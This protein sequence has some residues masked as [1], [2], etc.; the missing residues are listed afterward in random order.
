MSMP[1]KKI[2]QSIKNMQIET[3]TNE[4]GTAIKY[5]DGWM[6]CLLDTTVTDQALNRQY[7]NTSLFFGTRTWTFPV[8]FIEKPIVNCGRFQWGTGASWGN[9]TSVTSST[10]RLTGMDFLSRAVG[11]SVEISA[12]AIGRWK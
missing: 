8:Q 4:N 10:A 12:T 7:S 3:I 9:V 6:I 11:T 2:L 5:P 1:L